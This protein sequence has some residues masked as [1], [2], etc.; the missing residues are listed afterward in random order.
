[1]KYTLKNKKL[2]VIFESKGATLHSIKDNDG[3][4]YLWEGNPEYCPVRHQSYSQ[5]VEVSE[6]IKHRSVME[7]RQTCQDM[8]L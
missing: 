8:V 3:V 6:M 1:M 4:E 5:S 7:N 2:T